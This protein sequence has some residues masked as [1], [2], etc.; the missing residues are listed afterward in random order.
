MMKVLLNSVKD[1][2]PKKNL[3]KLFPILFVFGSLAPL[4]SNSCKSWTTQELKA[5]LDKICNSWIAQ[6]DL[7]E[8]LLKGKCQQSWAHP[9]WKYEATRVWIRCPWQ[10][11]HMDWNRLA[12]EQS[13]TL[14]AGNHLSFEALSAKSVPIRWIHSQASG[15]LNPG[16]SLKISP[17]QV[18]FWE[19]G[20]EGACVRTQAALRDQDTTD[21][22]APLTCAENI[23]QRMRPSP[24]NPQDTRTWVWHKESQQT[25]EFWKPCQGAVDSL[26]ILEI[27]HHLAEPQRPKD[28]K[29][30]V[31]ALEQSE[32][33]KRW[34]THG[35]N[36]PAHKI[37]ALRSQ[38][39]LGLWDHEAQSEF[40][41]LWDLREG[42][43]DPNLWQLYALG[44]WVLPQSE[45]KKGLQTLRK[46]PWGWKLRP[47]TKPKRMPK[48]QRP[49]HPLSSEAI[50]LWWR[51]ENFVNQPD[52]NWIQA[53]TTAFDRA[54]G[55]S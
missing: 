1:F 28:P 7:S 34:M 11:K 45:I 50:A 15:S 29:I 35:S 52:P 49:M 38:W 23:L 55:P 12:C 44:Q 14:S 37:R 24:Q 53:L 30:W 27:W 6:E 40:E 17:N 4:W 13:A 21:L 3:G 26:Q 32:W 20:F 42:L 22:K 8:V 54:K 41:N 16:D 2:G 5:K 43:G 46:S 39:I 48:Q 47:E 10:Q 36:R 9:A 33:L 31:R 19:N 51:L 18:V 25:F